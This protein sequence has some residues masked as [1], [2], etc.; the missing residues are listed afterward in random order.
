MP[1]KILKN[2]LNMGFFPKQYEDIPMH[3]LAGN[4]VCIKNREPK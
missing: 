4:F 3:K 2:C 1:I